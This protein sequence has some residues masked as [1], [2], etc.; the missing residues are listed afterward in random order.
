MR[1]LRKTLVFL[2]A[3]FYVLGNLALAE[4]VTW[5]QAIVHVHTQESDGLLTEK[6]ILEWC[7]LTGNKLIIFN[8]HLPCITGRC[9][10]ENHK[11]RKDDYA[12]EYF[13]D[14]DY[15]YKGI[16]N[17]SRQ[18][19]GYVFGDEHYNFFFSSDMVD[20]EFKAL[21]W[22]DP[23]EIVDIVH[24]KAKQLNQLSAVTLN[25]PA[26]VKKGLVIPD[27][28]DAIEFFNIG[29]TMIDKAVDDKSYA[30]IWT[31]TDITI[32]VYFTALKKYLNSYNPD[33]LPA[34]IGGSDCHGVFGELNDGKTSFYDHKC[35]REGFI[36]AINEGKTFASLYD[37]GIAYSRIIELNYLP[38]KTPY[39]VSGEV[40]LTGLFDLKVLDLKGDVLYIYRDG[41]R[42]HPVFKKTYFPSAAVKHQFNFTDKPKPGIHAYNLYMRGRLFTSAIVFDVQ[43]AREIKSQTTEN[44][45]QIP[46][47]IIQ[48]A[49]AE[50]R[51]NAIIN[52]MPAI[53]PDGRKIAFVSN[54]DGNAEVYVMNSNGTNQERITYDLAPDISPAWTNDSNL[55][56]E[57]DRSGIRSVWY[58]NLQTGKEINLTSGYNSPCYG[59]YNNNGEIRCWINGVVYKINFINSQ[60]WSFEQYADRL[61]SGT[62]TTELD[63]PCK[64]PG[65]L[66]QAL[67]FYVSNN[68]MS[69]YKSDRS[70]IKFMGLPFVIRNV[71]FNQHISSNDPL[72]F[73]GSP[74]S[75]VQSDIY[76]TDYNGSFTKQVLCFAGNENFISAYRRS[77]NIYLVFDGEITNGTG[78]RDI[79]SLRYGNNIPTRLTY[80]ADT[81]QINQYWKEE[82]ERQK[83][84]QEEQLRKQQ[85]QQNQ[86]NFNRVM[87]EVLNRVKIK[88]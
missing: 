49:K 57:S 55:L 56:F 30:S 16:V 83:K 20:D 76:E 80:G 53:S 17:Y 27:R 9:K 52:T 7:V 26:W 60:E 18:S 46:F 69:T 37:D 54:R 64:L 22:R 63:I 13:K 61:T 32:D 12:N 25:H 24:N 44:K 78:A 82:S 33:D 88:F 4:K 14:V 59:P 75:N 42:E 74:G 70:D 34:V 6:A 45:P 47:D 38:Q 71:A 8:N 36:K 35:T 79:F 73:I 11:H 2:L 68:Q 86:E 40:H 43:L 77:S 51:P 10:A 15:T 3:F 31:L 1:Q 66:S 19:E 29:G 67:N 28:I 23:Q 58:H 84:I 41:D 85:E 87:N 65:D 48:I 81:N 21:D 39:E 62:P 50:S 72:F 5:Q